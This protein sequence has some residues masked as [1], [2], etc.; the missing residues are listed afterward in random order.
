MDSGLVTEE[1]TWTETTYSTYATPGSVQTVGDTVYTFPGRQETVASSVQKDRIWLRDVGGHESS[2]TITG[3]TFD[4]RAGHVVSR[5][6]TREGDK[7]QFMVACNHVTGQF[8]VFPGTVGR[9][10]GSPN[11]S[12]SR[13]ALLIGVV[14]WVYG[15]WNLIPLLGQDS[16]AENLVGFTIMGLIGSFLIALFVNGRIH[17]KIFKMRNAYFSQKY[18]PELRQF[19]LQQSPAVIA[20]FPTTPAHH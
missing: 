4:V 13:I 18:L 9:Y 7:V 3:G 10:H 17:G 12:S 8:V 5:V 15:G 2:W 19:L 14:G 20:R 11:R 16:F 1:K 6:G